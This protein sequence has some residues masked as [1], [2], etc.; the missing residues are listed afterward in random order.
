[1]NARILFW[2]VDT[3]IDFMRPSGKLYVPQAESIIENLKALTRYGSDIGHL[4]S[5]SVDAHIPEDSEFV[6]FYEHCVR[7]T[8]GQKKIPE[9]LL[10][11]PL[12]VPTVQLTYGQIEEVAAHRV[13]V[14][15][16]KQTTDCGTNPNVAAYARKVGAE[17]AVVYG[18]V[19][20]ICVDKAVRHL[21][22]IGIDVVVVKDAIKELDS[23]KMERVF[24]NWEFIGARFATTA[25]ILQGRF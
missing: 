21:K 17:K 20:E 25:D 12:Y 5:G 24:M 14:I 11:E 19:T 4:M 8:P 15:F 23:E 1:M 10:G 6:N 13:Q 16:E 9:T 22:D 2:D 3:Q 7:G 18:V